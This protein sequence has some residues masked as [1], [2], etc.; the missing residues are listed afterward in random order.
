MA[1]LQDDLICLDQ[2][3]K[4]LHLSIE[5]LNAHIES[6]KIKAHRINGVLVVPESEIPSI[7]RDQF[8]ELDGNPITY[9]QAEE[10]YDIVG[11]TLRHWAEKGWIA[12]QKPGYG[13][14]LNEADVAFCAAVYHARL[15]AGIPSGIPLLDEM[16]RPYLQLKHPKLSEYRRKRKKALTKKRRD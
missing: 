3:A 8:C 14:E 6:G 5:Q 16:G 9:I 11:T 10:K 12:V 15:K 7:T 4:R 1:V 13:A 2:A